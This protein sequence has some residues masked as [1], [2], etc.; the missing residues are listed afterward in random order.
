MA[1]INFN[2]VAFLK[3]F[4]CNFLGLSNFAFLSP[5][6]EAHEID[7]GKLMALTGFDGINFLKC[8]G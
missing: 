5:S 2:K 3:C 4:G 6:T 1:L 7:A 8:F